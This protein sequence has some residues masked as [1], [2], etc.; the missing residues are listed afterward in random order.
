MF[1]SKLFT[2]WSAAFIF[3]LLAIYT[4]VVQAAPQIDSFGVD[5]VSAIEPGTELEFTLEGTPKARVSLRITGVPRTIFL[6]ETE[7]GFYE[8]TY[9]V[10]KK[11]RIPSNAS[12]RATL[13][14]GKRRT[15][16]RLGERL[17]LAGAPSAPAQP[18]APNGPVSIDRFTAD[19]IERFEPGAELKL[20]M[21]GTPRGRASF[22]IENIVTNRTMEEVRPGVYEGV[23]TIRRQDNFTPAL[24]V[25][26][27]LQANGQMAREQLDRR[28]VND[29]DPPGVSNVLPRDNEHVP[30]SNTLTVSGTFDDARGTGVDPKTVKI[31]LD[32]KD[33]TGQST[34][35]SQNFSY[36]PVNLA[37]GNHTVEVRARD[38]VGNA[39][40]T[41]WSFYTTT[42]TAAGAGLPL[43]ILSPRNNSEVGSG[44]IEVRG[45]TLPYSS[46]DVDV[47]AGILGLT[48]RIFDNNLKADGQGYFSFSFQPQVRVP[49]ARY[50]VN[51]RANKDRETR[52]RKIT[53]IQER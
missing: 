46:I 42:E 39:S 20:T 30:S 24:R 51:V 2:L 10:R 36:R 44:A 28:L 21:T 5:Q 11:D 48:Q 4:S 22:T 43:E 12:V 17:V 14:Q 31:L 34:I 41:N 40:R 35:T 13:R 3:A 8:G 23:Y 33:V 7:S 53:L 49:G 15:V 27:S 32:G 37:P 38:Q 1:N 47:T 9:T 26:G 6:R 50:E 19:Q 25:T 52:E 18:T 29:N 45:R 16:A